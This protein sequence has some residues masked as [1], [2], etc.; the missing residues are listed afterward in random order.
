MIHYRAK[1]C[2]VEGKR[3][4]TKSNYQGRECK[5]GWDAST[6]TETLDLHGGKVRRQVQSCAT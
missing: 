2:F 6:P 5:R 1:H 4:I 3:V